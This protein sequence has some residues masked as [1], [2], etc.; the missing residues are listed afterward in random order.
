MTRFQTDLDLLCCPVDRGSL[1]AIEGAFHCTSC[2]AEF[3]DLDGIPDLVHSTLPVVDGHVPY[4]WSD[5]FYL[6]NLLRQVIR[7]GQTV[8]EV[9]SGGN[10]VVPLLL[11]RLGIEVTYYSVGLDTAH[12]RQQQRGVEYPIRSVRGD[13]TALPLPDGSVDVYLGHHAINDVWLS[14]GEA[15]VEASYDEMD[16]VVHPEGYIV[17]SDCV[18]QHDARV[19]DPSTKL[20]TLDGLVTFLGKHGYQWLRDSGGELDWVVASRENE[21]R[22]QPPDDFSLV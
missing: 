12:L 2:Q 19:G 5:V 22:L 15:G 16:R 6:E 11:R 14:R 7:Q 3:S 8:V 13:A 20:V 1:V 10:I 17:Q 4:I 21:V 9:C 18:L